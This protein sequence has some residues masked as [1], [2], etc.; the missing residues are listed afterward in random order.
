LFELFREKVLVVGLGDWTTVVG[1]NCSSFR[2]ESAW[3]LWLQLKEVG[4]H[5]MKS[6]NLNSYY[7]LQ[8][9]KSLGKNE[10]GMKKA[11]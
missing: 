5:N 10:N 4:S 9:I 2:G 3:W 8:G 1:S 6:H 11:R 7:I